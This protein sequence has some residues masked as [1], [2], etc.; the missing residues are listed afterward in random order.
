[1]PDVSW[2]NGQDTISATEKYYMEVEKDMYKL[3]I[4]KL[5]VSDSGQWKC[6]ALNAYGQTIT[7]CTLT[8]LG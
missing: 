7:S 2:F 6:L 3:T 4:E 1:M 8:V 5:E